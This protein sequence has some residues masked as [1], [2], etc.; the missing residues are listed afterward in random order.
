MK[1]LESAPVFHLHNGHEALSLI[2]ES[3][4]VPTFLGRSARRLAAFFKAQAFSRPA[5][6]VPEISK[7]ALL[8]SRL[9]TALR[10]IALKPKS[11]TRH[12]G[13]AP[14]DVP[15]YGLFVT[16]GRVHR[17]ALTRAFLQ[18][19]ARF[20][21]RAHRALSLSVNR[22]PLLRVVQLNR[23][24]V[25]LH[26]LCGDT[27]TTTAA[28]SAD[29]TGSL[30]AR[31]S[32]EL[33]V[34]LTMRSRI[35]FVVCGPAAALEYASELSFA[36]AAREF[37]MCSFDCTR[38]ELLE[39]LSA[40]R[41]SFERMH[42]KIGEELHAKGRNL[43]GLVHDPERIRYL[44]ERHRGDTL[45]VARDAMNVDRS[46][47]EVVTDIADVLVFALDRDVE[48]YFVPTEKMPHGKGLALIARAA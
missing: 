36:R 14:V 9:R 13:P 31:A 43:E 2:V 4:K 44:I 10:R 6:T 11:A 12:V 29:T 23:D 46:E 19:A 48:I 24:G 28:W 33:E 30:S 5:Q 35:P 25:A 38:M 41:G 7:L 45:F 1:H 37:V 21:Q 34:L 26:E 40:S 42:E 47:S 8:T 32:M 39:A 3:E 22:R 17:I 27:L 18:R 20:P 16:P 15:A